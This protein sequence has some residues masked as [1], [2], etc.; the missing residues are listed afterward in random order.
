[1]VSSILTF[2]ARS[3]HYV[4]FGFFIC[5]KV[6]CCCP[7]GIANRPE[8]C[9]G[10]I[11]DHLTSPEPCSVLIFHV[12]LHRFGL[13]MKRKTITVD[14]LRLLFVLLGS[15]VKKNKTAANVGGKFQVPNLRRKFEGAQF[16]RSVKGKGIFPRLTSSVE[17]TDE[18]RKKSK[19]ARQQ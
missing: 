15:A 13:K 9:F 11:I 2:G 12:H 1:M 19:N 14:E 4:G 7:S 5:R 6:L 3:R 16:Q 8:S 18:N 17:K 10:S